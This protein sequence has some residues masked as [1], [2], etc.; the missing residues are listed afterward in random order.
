[1]HLS[2]GTSNEAVVSFSC[3]YVE[4][5]CVMIQFW[6]GLGSNMYLYEYINVYLFLK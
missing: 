5:S 6:A 2:I 1:M 4:T 3:Y